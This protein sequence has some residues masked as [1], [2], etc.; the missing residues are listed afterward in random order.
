MD[1]FKFVE[2]DYFST[3]PQ[4]L[5]SLNRFKIFHLDKLVPKSFVPRS[6]GRH[7]LL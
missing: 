1:E 3:L 5:A 6:E 7:L 2:V 4:R